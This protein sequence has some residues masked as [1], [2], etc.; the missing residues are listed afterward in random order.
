MISDKGGGGGG[1]SQNFRFF[2]KGGRVGKQRGTLG[3]VFQIRRAKL[4][5]LF[6]QHAMHQ[7]VSP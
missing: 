5:Q 6:S 4:F 1:V 7:Y 3:M 2:Y